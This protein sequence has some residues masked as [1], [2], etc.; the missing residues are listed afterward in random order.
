[1][2]DFSLS[3]YGSINHIRWFIYSIL[4]D[5]KRNYI[6]YVKSF[7]FCTC[8]IFAESKKETMLKQSILKSRTFAWNLLL[9]GVNCFLCSDGLPRFTD[10]FWN[11]TLFGCDPKSGTNIFLIIRSKCNLGRKFLCIEPLIVFDII[12]PDLRMPLSG[13]PLSSCRPIITYKTQ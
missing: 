13:R 1:M 11:Y 9:S 4:L 10:V 8:M 6:T 5:L 7:E 2:R 12:P 3:P